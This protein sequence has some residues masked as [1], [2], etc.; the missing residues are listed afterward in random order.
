MQSKMQRLHLSLI[1]KLRKLKIMELLLKILIY[2]VVALISIAI[3]AT[4]AILGGLIIIS[5][6]VFCVIPVLVEQIKEIKNN[7]DNK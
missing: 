5:I 7:I 2:I 3:I 6:T 4:N 1:R